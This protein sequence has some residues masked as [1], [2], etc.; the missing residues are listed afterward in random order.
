MFLEKPMK[1]ID[2]VFKLLFNSIESNTKQDTCLS[3]F[4]PSDH[5][6]LR[7]IDY[8]NIV[9]NDGIEVFCM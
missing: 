4:L 1:S 3:G 6:Y 8:G 7:D 2:Q 9:D 5:F